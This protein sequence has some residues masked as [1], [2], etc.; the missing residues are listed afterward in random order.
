MHSC[1]LVICV[2]R[3][4]LL[5]LWRVYGVSLGTVSVP[6]LPFGNGDVCFPVQHSYLLIQLSLD[7]ANA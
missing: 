4:R 3:N 6:L 1:R 2:S 5:G 7:L